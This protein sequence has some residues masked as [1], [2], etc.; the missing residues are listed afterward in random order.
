MG[1]KG[2]EEEGRRGSAGG[3]GRAGYID[4]ADGSDKPVEIVAERE[5]GEGGHE[6]EEEEGDGEPQR[7][8][9]AT[10]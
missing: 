6:A 1:G 4:A 3:R 7:L 5:Q 2:R 9:R 10:D 8:S